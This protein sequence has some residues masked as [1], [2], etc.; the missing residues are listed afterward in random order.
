MRF[1]W[2]GRVVAGGEVEVAGE[3]GRRWQGECEAAGRGGAGALGSGTADRLGIKAT[4]IRM[5]HMWMHCP[6]QDPLTH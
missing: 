3:G 2:E 6:Q 5:G 4:C 1:R